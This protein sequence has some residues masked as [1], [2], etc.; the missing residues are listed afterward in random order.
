MIINVSFSMATSEPVPE[1]VS[2]IKRC[3]EIANKLRKCDV[4]SVDA[5][6]VNLGKDG[7]LTLLQIGTIDGDVYLFDVWTNQNLFNKGKLK[8]ILQSN[9]IVKVFFVVFIFDTF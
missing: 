6:G 5:E 2:T 9:E 7:P 1:V 8:T 4:I 3:R